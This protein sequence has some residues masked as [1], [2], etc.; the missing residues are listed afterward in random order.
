MFR[1]TSTGDCAPAKKPERNEPCWCGSGKKYKKCH[2]HGDDA[3]AAA[4]AC[5]LNCGPT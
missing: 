5:S 1:S 3:K 4:Q 2:L